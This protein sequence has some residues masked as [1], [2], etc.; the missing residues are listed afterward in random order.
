MARRSL[1]PSATPDG[2]LMVSAG[3]KSSQLVLDVFEMIGGVE[4]MAEWAEE[5]PG[6]FYTK[7]FGKTITR[8][9]EANHTVGIEQL[10]D[11]LDEAEESGMILDG[12]Y[13]DVTDDFS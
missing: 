10:L 3:K 7:L 6:E 8:E 9:V 13:E 11:T 5:N 2:Q 12:E 1:I 4:R